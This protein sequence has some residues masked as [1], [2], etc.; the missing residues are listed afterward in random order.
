VQ[1]SPTNPALFACA[2][3][4]GRLDL[5][6]LINDTEVPTASITIDGA[7]ALNKIRW[8]QSGHQ[9]AIGDDQGRITLLDM[10][11]T[12]VN[13][14][15]DDWNKLCKVLKDLKENS[16]QSEDTATTTG[17]L[18]NSLSA[19]SGINSTTPSNMFPSGLAGSLPTVKSEPSFDM[20]RNST[21][22]GTPVSSLNANT[23]KVSPQ[24]PK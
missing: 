12:F 3:G 4:T 18:S 6:N 8:S 21:N 24:T 17:T 2:D 5:W 7:P 14:R 20:S 11:E 13:P 15:Q 1:W 22:F 10:N 23:M 19:S 9:I 16:N